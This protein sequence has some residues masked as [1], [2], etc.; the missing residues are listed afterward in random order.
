MKTFK[1]VVFALLVG[2]SSAASARTIQMDVNGLVCG[3]CA[4]GIEKSLR[5]LPATRGVFVSLADR[6]V[7]VEVKD[8]ADIDDAVLRRTLT[9]AG[10]TVKAIRRSPESLDALRQRVKRHG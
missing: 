3:F 10:Y 1:S 5:T 2:V 6:L 8:D 9:N 7:A 4:Q